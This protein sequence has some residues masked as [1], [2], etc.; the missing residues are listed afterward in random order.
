[1]SF[2]APQRTSAAAR[3]ELPEGE[4]VSTYDHY[5]DV[6]HAVATLVQH[7]FPARHLSIVG[8]GVKTVERITAKMSYAR[9]ALMG[10]MSGAYMGAFLGLILFIFQPDNSAVL[11]VVLAAVVIGAGFG[12]L[13]A[14]VTYSLNRNRREFASVTQLI[15]ERYDLMTDAE[16]LHEARRILIESTQPESAD[17]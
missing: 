10:A 1:M 16:H 2:L 4:I 6:Q 5:H 17:A 11:G 8:N 12:M 14:V 7:D 9:V 13:F 15:G 3:L